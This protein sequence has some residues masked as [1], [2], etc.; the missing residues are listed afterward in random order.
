MTAY[1]YT[2]MTPYEIWMLVGAGLTIIGVFSTLVW[3]IGRENGAKITQ[4]H[5]RID[6]EREKSRGEFVGEK[7]FGIAITAVNERIDTMSESVTGLASE[8]K[9]SR[10]DIKKLLA[11]NGAK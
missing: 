9:E 8:V 6:L 3:R 1:E 11:R 2:G 10:N 7:V 4:I 5:E